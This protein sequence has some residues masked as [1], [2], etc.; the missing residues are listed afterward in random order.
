MAHA[1]AQRRQAGRSK[2]SG[3]Y[4][5]MTN[6]DPTFVSL[7]PLWSTFRRR[8]STTKTQ[9][10]RRGGNRVP[11]S[12]MCA[13][14]FRSVRAR[15]ITAAG[16]SD[17]PANSRAGRDVCARGAFFKP[18]CT[19][20]AGQPRPSSVPPL[21]S[22]PRARSGSASIIAWRTRTVYDLRLRTNLHELRGRSIALKGAPDR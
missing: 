17:W 6:S 15:Q 9:R 7:V 16:W 22:L 2:A 13:R 1:K 10:T 4:R 3:R 8:E 11:L 14:I 21:A 18:L 5:R 12:R 19:S 20:S